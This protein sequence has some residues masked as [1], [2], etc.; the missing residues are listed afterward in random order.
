[1]DYRLKSHFNKTR[2]C[3]LVGTVFAQLVGSFGVQSPPLHICL[4]GSRGLKSQGHL[5]Q[6]RELDISLD[7][8][9]PGSTKQNFLAQLAEVEI[10]YSAT[11]NLEMLEK[12]H[13]VSKC[14]MPS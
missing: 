2:G 5:Q 10:H 9:R 4:G 13:Q 14:Q 3:S 11:V 7:F 8:L 12:G 6:C 1:M